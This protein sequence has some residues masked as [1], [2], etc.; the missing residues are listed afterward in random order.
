MV[1]DN[2]SVLPASNSHLRASIAVDVVT[3]E[4]ENVPVDAIDVVER[5]VPVRPVGRVLHITQNR[6]REKTFLSSA[7]LPVTPFQAVRSSLDLQQALQEAKSA[8]VLKTADWGYDGKGQQKV[9]KESDAE[10]VWSSIDSGEA[11]LE[12]FV[13]FES[14]LSVVAA[15]TADGQMACY[16]PIRNMNVNRILDLSVSPSGCEPLTA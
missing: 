5:Y 7:G 11:I 14:E 4:F 8:A 6:L 15:R 10:T 16:E 3:F 12:E 2:V 1:T 9:E 13:D